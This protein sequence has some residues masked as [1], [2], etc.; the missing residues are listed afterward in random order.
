MKRKQ[1]SNT[2]KEE[3][4]KKKWKFFAAGDMVKCKERKYTIEA[5]QDQGG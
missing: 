4:Q 5:D 2:K 1:I 3:Q